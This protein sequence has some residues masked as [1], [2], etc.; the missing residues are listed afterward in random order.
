L[1]QKK[2]IIENAPLFLKGGGEM[3]VLTRN[4]D[5]SKTTLGPIKQWGQS[6]RTIVAM[7]L[8]SKSPMFLWWG[9]DLIQFY[10]D[11]YRPS[12]GN[13]GKHPLA[14]GQK[15]KDCWT[16]IWDIIFPLIQQVLTTG[17][18]IWS[19]DQLIPIYRDGKIE[20]VYWTFGYSPLRGD[21]DT[22]EGILVVCQ[23]T[24]QK[25][26]TVQKLV[27]SEQQVRSLVESAPFPIGVYIGKEMRIV[28][29][30]QAILNVWG[31]GNNVIGKLYAEVLPELHNQLIFEQLDCVY[32]SGIAFHARNQRMDLTVDSELRPYYFNYSFTPLF[33]ARG[34]VYG[35]MNTAADV[36]DLNLA[37]QKV[38]ENEKS[39]RNTILKAPVAMCIFRG[40]KYIVE[41][42]N[43]RMIELWGKPSSDVLGKP[44]FEGLP[45]AKD[46][47]FEQILEDVYN[48]GKT[49]S[50]Q[51]TPITLPRDGKTEIVY[52]NFLYEAYREPNRS[53]SGIIAVAIEVTNQVSERREI[54][55]IV[56]SRTIELAK[57][58]NNL[59]KSNDELERF[60]YVASHDLQEPVRKMITFSDLLEKSLGNID[61]HSK[62]YLNKIKNASSRMHIL[63]RDLLVYSQLSKEKEVFASVDLQEIVENI[64]NDFELL[65]GQKEASLEYTDLPTI[66]AV[67]LGMSQLLGNLLSNS[68]KFTRPGIN[69]VINITA[70][71]MCKEE[72]S[73]HPGLSENEVYY[74]IELRDNGI[75]FEQQYAEQIFSIFQRL[76]GNAEY[77]GTGI[78]L[79][80]CKKIAQNH[81]GEIY[82]TGS[83]ESGAVFNVILPAKQG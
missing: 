2:T 55:K 39:F 25:V 73:K 51:D 28:L 57:A 3:G 35:V 6:L 65:I 5:W 4:F 27:E 54:E 29:A 60:A 15:G 69:P 8:S 14:L 76:H 18:A 31:K 80:M 63:I 11:A 75:G 42:A 19:E 58:N 62:F 83:L 46:Q 9:E 59:L 36:T 20:D 7:I 21:T 67:P 37:K 40:P 22:I 78:G 61:V 45:E 24:T 77:T 34:N 12:L 72:V 64:K 1:D 43:E 49:F 52:V 82:A 48:T 38:E 50:A 70:S 41:I 17:E 79:A 56:T 53:I 30:N 44:I 33:D 66:E 10:N 47:G 13:I 68:L 26:Q 16:D 74:N 32:T 23:E 71:I 81:H